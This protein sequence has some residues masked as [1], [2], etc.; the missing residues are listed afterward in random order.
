[1]LSI[2]N[3]VVAGGYK[4]ASGQAVGTPNQ[5]F[6]AGTLEMQHPLFKARGFD[7]G[8][9]IP[10]LFWGTI[11]V[12][13]D[14]RLELGDSPWTRTLPGIDW[15]EGLEGDARISPETF[16]FVPCALHH[17]GRFHGGFLYYPHP[18]TKP[19]TNGHH[20][21]RFEVLAPRVPG[22]AD[23]QP[24]AVICDTAAFRPY[25]GG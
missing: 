3:G 21:D 14:E 15:T 23:G 24:A 13:L 20:Y 10:G 18:E 19:S 9:E 17:A 4:L 7:L 1:M 6:P 5:I 16:S 12:Q 8:Q 2:Y 22:L 25:D 11:N